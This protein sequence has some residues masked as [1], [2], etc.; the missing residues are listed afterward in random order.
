MNVWNIR[1]IAAPGR[2]ALIL[3]I[4]PKTHASIV[5]FQET[6]K[7]EFSDSFLKSLV[8][9][10]N[11]SW[12]HLPAQGSAGGILMGVDLDLF[13]VISWSKL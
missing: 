3:E 12:Y 2:K 6:K 8:G 9:N 1:G 11:F 7:E 5:G 10:R 13:D 4:L